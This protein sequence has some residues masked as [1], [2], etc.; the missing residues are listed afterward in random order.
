MIRRLY[1][2]QGHTHIQG[3]GNLNGVQGLAVGADSGVLYR[4]NRV[5]VGDFAGGPG[6][7]QVGIERQWY[8][9]LQR[10]M[11]CQAGPGHIARREC[12]GKTQRKRIREKA[13]LLYVFQVHGNFLFGTNISHAVGKQVGPLLLHQAGFFTGFFCL[14]VKRLCLGLLPD[15][16]N[17]AALANHHLQLAHRGII[18]QRKSVY[19]LHPAFRVIAKGLL[20]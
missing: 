18:R 17:D 16:A 6:P 3:R 4:G 13:H 2:R 14:L 7:A 12:H 10:S 9:L 20:Q 11:C 19:A 5:S 1:L 15:F 8:F